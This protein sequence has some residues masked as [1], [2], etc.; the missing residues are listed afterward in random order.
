MKIGRR[1]FFIAAGFAIFA[2]AAGGLLMLSDRAGR[3]FRASRP[4]V[5][6]GRVKADGDFKSEGGKLAG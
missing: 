4:K 5:F 1:R 2:A 6:P 3:L